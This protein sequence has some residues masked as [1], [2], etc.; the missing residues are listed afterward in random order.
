M[1][2]FPLNVAGKPKMATIH[3]LYKL[4]R[5]QSSHADYKVSTVTQATFQMG[6]QHPWSETRTQRGSHD[7]K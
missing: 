5:F 2:F 3:V 6:N 1:Y 7:P 4:S